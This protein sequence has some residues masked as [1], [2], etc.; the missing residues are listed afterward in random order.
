[1]Y[2]PISH[3]FHISNNAIC[4]QFATLTHRKRG[5]E[6]QHFP[7]PSLPAA[8]AS[9][10]S[11]R[12]SF[13]RC[14]ITFSVLPSRDTGEHAKQMTWFYGVTSLASKPWSTVVTT[15]T[16]WFIIRNLCRLTILSLYFSSDSQ[17]REGKFPKRT[18]TTLHSNG[19]VGCLC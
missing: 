15:G 6:E 1:M 9:I 3:Q 17:N 5:S 8:A 19:Q 13:E 10:R 12:V 4:K 16:V 18:L 14:W 7:H 2:W 11:K